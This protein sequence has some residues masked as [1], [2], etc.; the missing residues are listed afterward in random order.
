MPTEA[1][2]DI[3]PLN[4]VHNLKSS[5][6]EPTGTNK[7][8]PSEVV[9][10]ILPAT[11]AKFFSALWDYGDGY[12]TALG[13]SFGTDCTVSAND[14]GTLCTDPSALHTKVGWDNVTGVGTPNAQ[15]FADSFS[16]AGSKK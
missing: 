13:L 5:I 7:Y 3:V 1:V 12:S 11:P 10:G 14:A 16:A 2:T 6:Q 15:A 4:S 8:T 9:G